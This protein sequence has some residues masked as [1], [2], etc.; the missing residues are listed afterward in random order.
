M[1]LYMKKVH[2]NYLV[3]VL[4]VTAMAVSPMASAFHAI[5]IKNSENP[6]YTP[7]AIGIHSYV[8][9]DWTIAIASFDYQA[10][11]PTVPYWLPAVLQQAKNTIN[12]L[13]LG[14]FVMVIGKVDS[15][16][17][18]AYVTPYIIT[19]G[20]IQ[21]TPEFLALALNTTIAN[22]TNFAF[23]IPKG[24]GIAPTLFAGLTS[25]GKVPI[26]P[27]GPM[28]RA[29]LVPTNTKASPQQLPSPSNL[30][31]PLIT[32]M[33]YNYSAEALFPPAPIVDPNALST[34]ESL[35]P[36]AVA[37]LTGGEVTGFTADVIETST[38]M[39][40]RIYGSN[41]TTDTES[42]TTTNVTINFI[43]T[44]DKATGVETNLYL[45]ANVEVTDGTST[46]SGELE[47][48]IGYTGEESYNFG[49][50]NGQQIGFTPTNISYSDALVS[51]LNNLNPNITEGLID[52]FIENITAV[53]VTLT[54]NDMMSPSGIDLF[55]QT[56]AYTKDGSTSGNI[57]ASALTFGSPYVLPA[58]D[59]MASISQTEQFVLTNILGKVLSYQVKKE[60]PNM[61]ISISGNY[62]FLL[63][64]NRTSFDYAS[65]YTTLNLFIQ[66]ITGEPVSMPNA[67]PGFQLK[68]KVTTWV[69]YDSSGFLTEIGVIVNITSF[70][71]DT[72]GDGNF[73]DEVVSF[74]GYASASI[75]RVASGGG[76]STASVDFSH[77][78]NPPD[79]SPTSPAWT[80]ITPKDQPTSP[81][82][83]PDKTGPTISNIGY[84]PQSPKAGETVKVTADVEDNSSLLNVILSYEGDNGWVNVTMH[85]NDTS[86]YYE[87]YITMP[88]ATTVNAKIYASDIFH[89][90]NVE[91]FTIGKTGVSGGLLSGQNAIYIGGAAL[92]LI[93]ILGVIFAFRRRG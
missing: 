13:K 82:V 86:G 69:T 58:W 57:M 17:K 54:Y 81:G 35:W 79:P 70:T 73:A 19:G 18:I 66:N 2:L 77:P 68:A 38:T 25:F 16:H 84:Y 64:G 61:T 87:A 21:V 33:P 93:V 74:H 47:L 41:T 63:H 88:N 9:H 27:Y 6:T 50:M 12:G 39:E 23:T 91:E 75:N 80:D 20:A 92:A 78:I 10:T 71:L 53:N 30:S 8:K 45:H 4:L 32:A 1:V 34:Y 26:T 36:M 89:N 65:S 60:Y 56:I 11:G 24:S 44:Y 14:K 29:L 22:A 28:Y 83:V 62:K 52:Q 46:V 59:E 5:P 49:L 7:K 76:L 42:G 43:A 72:D 90:W 3:A 67:H 37:N 55:Y 51:L 31:V 48:S 40:F 85:Y 15:V